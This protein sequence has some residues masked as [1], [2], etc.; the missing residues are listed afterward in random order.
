MMRRSTARQR[1]MTSWS[2]AY[3]S[4]TVLRMIASTAS[5]VTM[6]RTASSG[7]ASRTRTR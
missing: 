6:A 3:F 1:T 2:P 5:S 7:A 4:S